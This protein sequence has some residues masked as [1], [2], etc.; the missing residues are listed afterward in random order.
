M[1]G[2]AVTYTFSNSTTA[3]ATQVNQNFTDIINGLSDGT[4]DLSINALTV[5]GNASFSG[6]TTIGNASGDDLTVTASLASSIP[7]KTTNTYDIGSSTLGLR[8]LYFGANSQTVKLQG[9]SSMSATWTFTFPV[10][11]GTAGDQLETD[12]A[13]VTSWKAKPGSIYYS[14]YYPG[15]ASNY[16]SNANTSFGDFSVTGTIPTITVISSAG[17]T[18]TNAAS[19]L[20]G[21]AFTAPRTGVIRMTVV[22]PVLPGQNAIATNYGLKLIESGSS[23]LVS[24][25]GGGVT[26]NITTNLEHPVTLVGYFAATATSSYNFK[27]QSEI[28]SG[29]LYLGAVTNG[30]LLFAMEYIS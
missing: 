24:I 7:I 26:D 22:V 23:T 9:S 27:L 25:G 13:G 3:D 15:S 28:S 20:P 18:V 17:F 4:K 1:A 8:A 12:G 11:A 16:W 5:A 2:I 10:S 14:G 21:I 29:T 19:N 6:N 30:S